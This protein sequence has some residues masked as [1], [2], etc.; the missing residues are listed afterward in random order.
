LRDRTGA[1]DRVLE[2]NR[3]DVL[4]MVALLA[5]LGRRV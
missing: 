2:H 1:V 4:S 3:I 5:V